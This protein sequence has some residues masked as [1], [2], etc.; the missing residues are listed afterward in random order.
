MVCHV[1]L[2]CHGE[3]GWKESPEDGPGQGGGQGARGASGPQAS[4]QGVARGPAL[5]PGQHFTTLLLPLASSR[6]EWFK[7]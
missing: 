1:M 6:L 4:G 3:V 7:L 5:H 2:T